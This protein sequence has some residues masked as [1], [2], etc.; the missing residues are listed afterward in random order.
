MPLTTTDTRCRG[1]FRHDLCPRRDGC[2]RYTERDTGDQRTLQAI[3][4]C[5]AV[6]GE[7]FIES[8]KNA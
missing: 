6:A 4:M 2:A 1:V 7:F 5:L 3:A 8:E